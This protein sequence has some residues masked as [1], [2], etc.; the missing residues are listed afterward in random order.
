MQF[1]QKITG[2]AIN[3]RRDPIFGVKRKL[4]IDFAKILETSEAGPCLRML[5]KLLPH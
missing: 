5:N 1:G 4:A 2:E 3:F